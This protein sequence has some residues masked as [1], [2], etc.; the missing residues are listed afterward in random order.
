[1]NG[2]SLSILVKL[3]STYFL[4][5]GTYA[6]IRSVS[7]SIFYEHYTA[8]EYNFATGFTIFGLTFIIWL[9]S[10]AQKLIGIHKLYALIGIGT[11]AIF[12]FSKIFI[13]AGFP[14][15]AFVI[16]ATKE[17]YIV[18][19]V[20]LFLAFCNNFF[21]LDE[22][23]KLYGPLGAIGS[24]GGVIGG[25]LT[26]FF[27]EKLGTDNL[28]FGGA[29]LISLPVIIFYFTTGDKNTAPYEQKSEEE[30]PTPLKSIQ[31]VM[32]Y[33]L[34]VAI[35]V[36]L[37]QF[38]IYIANLQFNIVFEQSITSKD[39][40]TA[41]LGN[42]NSII[43]LVTVVIQ[44][45]AIRFIF[46][47]ASNKQILS[48]LPFVYLVFILIS[49]FLGGNLIY[50]ASSLFVLL[51]ASDYSIYSVAK[52]ILYYPLNSV[53]KYGAKYITDIW[54]YR[55]AKGVLALLLSFMSFDSLLPFTVLQCIF[56]ASWLVVIYFIFKY[57]EGMK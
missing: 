24:A 10:R 39:E 36:A 13:D 25:A 41:F 48:V 45:F 44:V 17:I 57:Q 53:Q 9:S 29:L 19:M 32:P 1:M 8:K 38:I 12:I 21:T 40:R 35:M 22:I 26:G 7:A 4:V 2:R 49:V 43:N 11:S 5:L 34:L 52:E 33:V 18:L 16:F 3:F 51:K 14:Q 56:V 55:I 42:L 46:T 54:G 23:K 47:R 30:K 50:V 31:G 37:T 6:L 15:F 28:Y 27:A 20:H